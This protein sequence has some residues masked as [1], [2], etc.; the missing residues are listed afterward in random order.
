MDL[1][2]TTQ[3]LI[4]K[5]DELEKKIIDANKIVKEYDELKKQL[6]DKM[7]EIGHKNNLDQVKWTTPNGTS[8]T[9]SIG[10]RPVW[11]KQKQMVFKE[12]ILKEKYPDIYTQCLKEE[13]HNILIEKGSNDILRIT[14]KKEG[15]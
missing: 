13:E 1:D 12:D 14:P 7:L 11:E 3:A 4:L 6:K 8:I 9:C 15:K 5:V 10:K 2:F